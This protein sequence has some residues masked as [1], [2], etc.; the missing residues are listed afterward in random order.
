M[1]LSNK[2]I[3]EFLNIH[4]KRTFQGVKAYDQFETK[5]NARLPL[6]LIVNA[7]PLRIRFGHW[8]ALY[9]DKNRHATF[10]DSYGLKPWGKFSTFFKNNAIYTVYNTKLLQ[11][12]GVSCGHHCIYFVCQANKGKRLNEILQSYGSADPDKIVKK[13]YFERIKSTKKKALSG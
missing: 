1:A 3:N 10:F 8:S 2:D 5:T 12:D 11:R 6:A 7:R 13:F 9:V 4:A